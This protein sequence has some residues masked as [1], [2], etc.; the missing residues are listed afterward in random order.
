MPFAK[1]PF[2]AIA[3]NHPKPPNFFPEN[4]G[5]G[6]KQIL[7][8]TA[9]QACCVNV[10]QATAKSTVGQGSLLHNAAPTH[11]SVV[12]GRKQTLIVNVQARKRHI[13]INFFVRLVLGRPRACPGDFTGCVPGT[14]SV[15]TWDKPGFSPYFTQWK[16]GKPGFVPGT[17]PGLSL[18]QTRGRRAAQKVKMK[19]FKG[20]LSAE[21][22]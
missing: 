5:A 13:N 18:G 21:R 14:N 4:G 3:R 9:R 8:C 19:K 16:P 22:N 20:G 15:K 12:S 1:K 11:D 2:E 10:S 7:F 6:A 17:S